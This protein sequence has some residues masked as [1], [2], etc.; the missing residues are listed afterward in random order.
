M[1]DDTD[2]DAFQTFERP[3]RNWPEAKKREVLEAYIAAE[4]GKKTA[5]LR[6]HGVSQSMLSRWANQLEYDIRGERGGAR[7]GSGPTP[8]QPHQPAVGDL[9][10]ELL[11]GEVSDGQEYVGI[12]LEDGD[13]DVLDALAFLHGIEGGAD[14]YVAQLVNDVLELRR[15]DDPVTTLIKLRQEH[16]AA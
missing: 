14:G 5:V 10:D 3:R 1:P 12:A 4:V 2:D 7:P 13:R 8:A 9:V 16:G 11:D 6:E 15:D